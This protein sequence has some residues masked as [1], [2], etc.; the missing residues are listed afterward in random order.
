MTIGAILFVGSVG[1][2]A[3]PLVWAAAVFSGAGLGAS[4]SGTTRGL[5]PEVKPHERAGLFAAIYL[6]A[7][8]AMGISAIVAGLFVGVVG[9]TAMAIGFGIVTAIV[10]LAGVLVTA[11]HNHRK[12]RKRK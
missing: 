9:V 8:L 11:G 7:Y 5:V 4:F 10:A 6:V 3:L 1:A 2:G 12:E